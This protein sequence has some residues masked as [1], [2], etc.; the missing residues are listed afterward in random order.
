MLRRRFDFW[1]HYFTGLLL[2]TFVMACR[3]QVVVSP[4]PDGS[5]VAR[6]FESVGLPTTSI[7][8]EVSVEDTSRYWRERVPIAR[9]YDAT[10]NDQAY[11][12]NLK[13]ES[14]TVLVVQ[15]LKARDAI[16][17]HDSVTVSGKVV[18][19]ELRSGTLDPQAP[20]GDMNYNLKGRPRG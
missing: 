9:L 2:A 19:I 1:L 13:W 8:Y 7:R 14:R 10:R 20:P 11:G 4:S 12:V 15:Y 3:N 6:V 18:R 17:L 16:L 5:V